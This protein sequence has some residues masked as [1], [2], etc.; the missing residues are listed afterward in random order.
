MS[1]KER[2]EKKV[3][4]KEENECWE[5]QGAIGSSGYGVIDEIPGKQIG[6]HRASW[7]IYR[8]QIPEG[9]HVLHTCDN[10]KCVN[11]NHLFLGTLLDNT[12]DC[13]LKG[14]QAKGEKNGKSKL[15]EADVRQILL[16]DKS[17]TNTCIARRFN[18]GADVISRIRS[19]KAWK[20]I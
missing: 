12:Q 16:L 15:T 14:R 7:L 6:S 20:H 19:R 9:I 11:P 2:F 8:G 10:R 3:L 5:W 13:N 4:K 17:F 1:L 18:V